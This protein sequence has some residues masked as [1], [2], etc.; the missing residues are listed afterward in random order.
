MRPW[1]WSPEL[2]EKQNEKEIKKGLDKTQ[3][4][5]NPN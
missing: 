4:Q 1:V 5:V 2:Q 3:G